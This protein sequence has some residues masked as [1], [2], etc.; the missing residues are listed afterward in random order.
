[1]TKFKLF[2]TRVLL[3]KRQAKQGRIFL[4]QSHVDN[5]IH[6]LAEIVDVGDGRYKGEQKEMLVRPGDLVYIQTNAVMAANCFYEMRLE[7]G[8]S[9]SLLNLEQ[10]ECIARLASDAMLLKDWEMLGEYVLLRLQK[11]DFEGETGIVVPDTV[12][13]SDFIYYEVEKFSDKCIWPLQKGQEVVVVHGRANHIVI[14][15]T[16]F[17]YIRDVDIHG[18]VE[19]A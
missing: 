17:A 14:E 5:D 12:R 9:D 15:G 7:G 4:P 11:R 3:R 6:S 2:G 8:K 19:E 13:R 16:E 1:M 18:I 10:T